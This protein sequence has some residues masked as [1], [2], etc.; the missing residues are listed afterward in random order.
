VGRTADEQKVRVA[1]EVLATYVG[2]YEETSNDSKDFVVQR[3]TVTLAGDQLFLDIGGKGRV[4]LYP[5]SQTTFSPRLL[6]TYEFMK[7]A[8][9]AVTHLIAYSTEGDV[10]AVRK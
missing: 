10:K 7:N 5:L 4:P 3:F 1:P 2:N 9:G 6:G 8:A